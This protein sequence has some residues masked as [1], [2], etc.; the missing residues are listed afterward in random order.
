M[1]FL[2]DKRHRDQL[3]LEVRQ[4]IPKSLEHRATFGMQVRLPPEPSLVLI[5]HVNRHAEMGD[6]FLD[7]FLEIET[8]APAVFVAGTPEE[9]D[10]LRG[11][12]RSY[13]MVVISY[14]ESPVDPRG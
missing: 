4:V 7:P 8:Y 9:Q 14:C 2:A 5:K 13:A 11:F 12:R 6:A 10:V 1:H 3:L